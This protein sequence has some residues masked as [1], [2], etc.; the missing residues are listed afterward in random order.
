MGG[1]L[2]MFVDF[3]RQA[4]GLFVGHNSEFFS[5]FFFQVV[6]FF[7]LNSKSV[8]SIW[9]GSGHSRLCLQNIEVGI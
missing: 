4:N 9:G 6:A 3:G 5:V 7:D 1:T 2:D 8:S